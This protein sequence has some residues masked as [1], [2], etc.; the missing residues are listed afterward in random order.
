MNS[1]ATL[2]PFDHGEITKIDELSLSG[3]TWEIIVLIGKHT[4]TLRFHPAGRSPGNLVL[5]QEIV[6]NKYDKEITFSAKP[7]C[8]YLIEWDNRPVI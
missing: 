2:S 6:S 5:L 3:T 1:F 4:I 8:E 7:G